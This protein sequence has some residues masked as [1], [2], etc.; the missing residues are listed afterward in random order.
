M[1]KP[2]VLSAAL[3][4][5]MRRDF[6]ALLGHGHRRRQRFGFVEEQ[7]FLFTASYLALGGKQSAQI[8]IESFLEQVALSAHD[9]QF[10][11][12]RFALRFAVRQC[13]T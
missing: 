5:A 8:G 3:G 11:L 10:A 7:I 9:A 2:R 12:Q 4:A 1:K 6:D 13:F